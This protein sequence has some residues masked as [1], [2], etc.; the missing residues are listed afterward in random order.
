MIDFYLPKFLL[1]SKSRYLQTLCEGRTSEIYLRHEQPKV[2][3]LFAS[4]LKRGTF[5][6]WAEYTKPVEGTEQY[7]ASLRKGR[8][9]QVEQLVK[10]YSMGDRLDSACFKNYVIDLLVDKLEEL[11]RSRNQPLE[12]SP[13]II[14]LIDDCKKSKESTSP[15]RRKWIPDTQCPPFCHFHQ[16]YVNTSLILTYCFRAVSRCWTQIH[17]RV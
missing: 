16:R 13:T 4:W 2:F 11:T 5:E 10:A 14:A 9:L 17:R 1:C 3:V 6:S 7:P 12:L 15:L 8:M